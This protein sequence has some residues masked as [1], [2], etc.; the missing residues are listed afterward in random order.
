MHLPPP[1]PSSTVL[2]RICSLLPADDARF[3]AS[4]DPTEYQTY[5]HA[6][7]AAR[8]HE[9]SLSRQLSSRIVQILFEFHDAQAAEADLRKGA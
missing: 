9:V 1:S 2:H 7:V 6:Y 4:L 3:I 5:V 8:R